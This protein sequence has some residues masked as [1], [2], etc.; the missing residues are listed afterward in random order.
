[1]VQSSKVLELN[2]LPRAPNNAFGLQYG[3]SILFGRLQKHGARAFCFCKNMTW[4]KKKQE[5]DLKRK[6]KEFEAY[7]QVYLSLL[8]PQPKWNTTQ[9]IYCVRRN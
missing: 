9:G 8:S 6:K 5:K 7:L 3:Q 1:M 4:Q 2:L